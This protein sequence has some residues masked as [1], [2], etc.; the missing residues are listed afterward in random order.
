[1]HIRMHII[2]YIIMEDVF[3]MVFLLFHR[4][5]SVIKQIVDILSQINYIVNRFINIFAANLMQKSAK[6]RTFFSAPC[7]LR[8]FIFYKCKIL[9]Y[10]YLSAAE[11]PLGHPPPPD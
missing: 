1:M 2:L 6:R 10:F 5:K 7:F 4:M 3:F 9:K 11:A 8:H